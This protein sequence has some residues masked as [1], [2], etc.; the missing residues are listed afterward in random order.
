MVSRRV[1]PQRK[2]SGKVL[3][4]GDEEEHISD[5]QG[6]DGVGEG[7][8]TGEF[9]SARNHD[10]IGVEIIH[11]LVGNQMPSPFHVA[12][13]GHVFVNSIDADALGRIMTP[14]TCPKLL[15][16]TRKLAGW[17]QGRNRV[18]QLRFNVDVL[19]ASPKSKT[20]TL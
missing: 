14:E 5:Q 6:G 12:A 11:S 13:I 20:S 8:N 9:L 19:E 15:A 17:Q 10:V 1:F 3:G 7:L 4:F 16:A 2:S 18:I